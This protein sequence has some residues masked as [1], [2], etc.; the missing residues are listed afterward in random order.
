MSRNDVMDKVQKIFRD[1]FDDESIVLRNDM[2]AEDIEDWDSFEQINLLVMMENEFNIKFDVK[3][4]SN[5]KNV[6]EMI[7]LIIKMISL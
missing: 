1:N 3:E 6:G 5:L 7:D 4:T 2:T